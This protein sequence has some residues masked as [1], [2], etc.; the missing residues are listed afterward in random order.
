M[1]KFISLSVSLLLTLLLAVG[2]FSVTAFA[3][4]LFNVPLE[5]TITYGTT[6]YSFS[7]EYGDLEESVTIT[8]TNIEFKCG[9]EGMIFYPT[10]PESV[11]PGDGT[12]KISVPISA[13]QW[14]ELFP[15][16]YKGTLTFKVQATGFSETYYVYLNFTVPEDESSS[17]SS[18]SSEISEESSEESSEPEESSEESSEADD[19]SEAISED[20]SEDSVESISD[21]EG[22]SETDSE[23]ESEAESETES[24]AE[25]SSESSKTSKTSNPGKPDTLNMGGSTAASGDDK[26]APDTGFGNAPLIALGVAAMAGLAVLAFRKK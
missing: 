25:E 5:D 21:T 17:E 6:D 2:M 4:P 12:F 20:S 10:G 7:V 3:E 8:Y 1:K 15:G 19:S 23:A 9:E 24:E 13:S 16:E 26:A 11:G 18:E 14:E 22:S